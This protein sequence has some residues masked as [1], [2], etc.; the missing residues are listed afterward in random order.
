MQSYRD[1]NNLAKISIIILFLSYKAKSS[2]YTNSFTRIAN[3]N[4]NVYAQF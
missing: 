3:I 4:K 2:I 1:R